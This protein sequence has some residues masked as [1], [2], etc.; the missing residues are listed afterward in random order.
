MLTRDE[1]KPE[2][3]IKFDGDD[4]ADATRY[5]LYSRQPARQAP[6][7]ARMAEDL[8]DVDPAMRQIHVARWLAEQKNNLAGPVPFSRRRRPGWR[9]R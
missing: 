1:K 5:L 4:A 9:H 8:K 6:K 7:E 3:A 2:D